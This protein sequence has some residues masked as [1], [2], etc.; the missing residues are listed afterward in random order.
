MYDAES[1]KYIVSILDCQ[2]PFCMF[3]LKAEQG[4]C[5]QNE[6]DDINSLIES[7]RHVTVRELREKMTFKELKRCAIF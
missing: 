3:S 6:I 5:R 7:D 2:I 4:S 1:L